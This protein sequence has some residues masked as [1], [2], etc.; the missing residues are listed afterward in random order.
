MVRNVESDLFHE[1][2]RVESEKERAS[3]RVSSEKKIK[4]LAETYSNSSFYGSSLPPTSLGPN[5]WVQHEEY[6]GLDVG[7]IFFNYFRSL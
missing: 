4:F 6:G 5:T 1:R 3:R 2:E 7:E